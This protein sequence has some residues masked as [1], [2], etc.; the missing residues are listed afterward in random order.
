VRGKPLMEL[1]MKALYLKYGEGL[2]YFHRIDNQKPE[3][4]DE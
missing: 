1:S 2:Y 4:Y 3:V